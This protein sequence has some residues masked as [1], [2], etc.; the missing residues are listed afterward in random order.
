MLDYAVS[1]RC[2]LLAPN[3]VVNSN[4]DDGADSGHYN[5]G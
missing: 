4:D 3:H 5:T 2:G 1:P